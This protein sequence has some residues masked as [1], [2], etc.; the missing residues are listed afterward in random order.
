ML[1]S[2]RFFKVF[3]QWLLGKL[4]GK[5]F[6]IVGAIVVGLWAGLTAVLL[7]VSV[8][9]LQ[10]LLRPL[11]QQYPIIHFA[12]PAFGDFIDYT[13]HQIYFKRRLAKRHIACFA[14]DR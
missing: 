4:S 9:Y 10:E 3:S 2:K 12:A 13:V 8:H 7:K 1:K 14:G 6:L 5:Q 11:G